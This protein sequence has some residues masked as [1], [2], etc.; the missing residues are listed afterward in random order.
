MDGGDYPDT[1]GPGSRFPARSEVVIVQKRIFLCV[2]VAFQAILNTF[3]FW[4]KNLGKKYSKSHEDTPPPITGK[5]FY[6]FISCFMP[7]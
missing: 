3:Y 1:P 6:I 2:F 4:V 7:F 5:I